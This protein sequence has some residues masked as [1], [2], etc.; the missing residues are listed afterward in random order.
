MLHPNK[1]TFQKRFNPESIPFIP[2]Y[3][4]S[5][6]QNQELN[7]F[8]VYMWS[9]NEQ[10]SRVRQYVDEIIMPQE[11]IWGYVNGCKNRR[12]ASMTEVR[13]IVNA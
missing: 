8:P 7:F 12:V 10:L 5:C 11:T 2:F 13:R 1:V 3:D 4:Q 9:E 6:K